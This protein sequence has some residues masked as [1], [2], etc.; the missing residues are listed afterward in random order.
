[1]G[2]CSDSKV[3][4]ILVVVLYM[5]CPL[6]VS[7]VCNAMFSFSVHWCRLACII[8]LITLIFGFVTLANLSLP[9]HLPYSLSQYLGTCDVIA[10]LNGIAILA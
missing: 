7:I 1:M 5:F 4:I 2:V 3:C 8:L 9:L 10:M 6:Y